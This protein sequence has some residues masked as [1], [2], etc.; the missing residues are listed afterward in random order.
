MT[1]RANA[2]GDTQATIDLDQ[3]RGLASREDDEAF[4]PLR[5]DEINQEIPRRVIDLRR[6]VDDI[7][8][9]IANHGWGTL[10]RWKTC[11]YGRHDH[12]L[13][14]DDISGR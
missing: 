14:T 6:L 13:R 12:V 10:I 11:H 7:I 2:A 3:L 5:P 8:A 1:E 9:A 4:L